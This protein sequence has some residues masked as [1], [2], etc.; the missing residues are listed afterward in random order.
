MK[1][2]LSYI[3]IVGVALLILLVSGL[4]FAGIFGQLLNVL[5]IVLIF[6]AFFSLFSTALLIYAIVMLIQTI[7]VVRD[8]MKPL[9]NSVQET[10]GVAKET[11]EAVK[12]T[13]QSAGKTASTLAG[14]A[15][16][17]REFAVA[18]PVRAAA[19]VLA[20]REMARVFVGKGHV[21]NRAEERKQRQARNLQDIEFAEPAGGG[22]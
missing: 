16:L 10:V 8:E 7:V 1:R 19:L 2:A 15:R 20:G 14:T 9:F 22:Q 3:K 13:A 11:V 5:Y 4:I 6:L 12:E 21:R 18:P 17:T